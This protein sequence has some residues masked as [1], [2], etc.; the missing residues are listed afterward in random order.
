[1]ATFR[2]PIGGNLLTADSNAYMVPYSNVNTGTT[3]DVFVW[4]FVDAATGTIKGTF[5]IPQNWVGSSKLII[6]WTSETTAG[7]VRWEIKHRSMLPGTSKFDTSTTPAEITQTVDTS[8][9]PGAASDLEEDSITLTATDL[10]VGDLVYFEF[11]RLGAHAND[12]KSAVVSLINL[13]FE[14]ADA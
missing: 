12:T 10:T 1:M 13:L 6:Q 14:Y 5:E 9:K 4:V 3:Q 7:N 8:S 11:S 2:L